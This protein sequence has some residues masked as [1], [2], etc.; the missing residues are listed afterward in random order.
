VL[1]EEAGKKLLEKKMLQKKEELRARFEQQMKE[2]D[3]CYFFNCY[4]FSTTSLANQK[5]RRNTL[6]M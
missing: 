3:V 6:K 1:D 2:I 5:A 4:F